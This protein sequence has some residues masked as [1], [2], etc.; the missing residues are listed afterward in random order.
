MLDSVRPGI[1]R[2]GNRCVDRHV[3][4]QPLADHAGPDRVFR[5]PLVIVII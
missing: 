5:I 2:D 3:A 1:A 4:D